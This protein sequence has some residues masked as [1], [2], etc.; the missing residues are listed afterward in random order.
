MADRWYPSSKTCSGCGAV[1][2]KLPL[3]VRTYRGEICGLVMDRD[4]NAA[5]NLA[6]LAVNGIAGTGVAGDQGAQAP[7]PRGAG[8]KT[9]ATARSRN[10]AGG[11][12]GGATPHQRK[13]T[14][15]RHQ[16][17]DTQLVPR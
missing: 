5:R 12:A 7:K 2:A 17:T 13:E 10:A 9:R 15:D 11:R 16:D 3:H 1:K 6:A 14:G 8:Q 4:Q